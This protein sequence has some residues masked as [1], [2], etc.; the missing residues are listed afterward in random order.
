MQCFIACSMIAEANSTHQHAHGLAVPLLAKQLLRPSK[1]RLRVY[2][3]SYRCAMLSNVQIPKITPIV[4]T[5]IATNPSK[6]HHL[7]SQISSRGPSL[8]PGT[9][10]SLLCNIIPRFVFG[11]SKAHLLR[12]RQAALS[13]SQVNR[14]SHFRLTSRASAS[15]DQLAM[16]WRASDL[17]GSFSSEAK[18]SDSP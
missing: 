10:P 13:G 3:A 6:P 8:R 16:T 4:P 11:V 14:R 1:P 2:E 9:L 15:M 5:K 7:G 17:K 12:D 18:E